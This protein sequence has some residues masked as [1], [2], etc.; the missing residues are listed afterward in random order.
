MTDKNL[1]A[2]MQNQ[3][4]DS[5][6]FETILNSN[7]F[8]L[9]YLGILVLIVHGGSLLFGF[10]RED[11]LLLKHLS[12]WNF[13]EKVFGYWRPV[14]L[15]WLS[16]QYTL[17]GLNP[18]AMH[19]VSLILFAVNCWLA[20]Y[21]IISLGI[22]R[23]VALVSV[24]LWIIMSG[25]IDA[26]VWISECNDLLAMFFLLLASLIWLF[27]C[28]GNKPSVFY[29]LLAGIC[30]LFSILNKEVGML[31]PIGA[32]IIAFLKSG[33]SGNRFKRPCYYY[34]V[35]SLPFVFMVIYVLM[36]IT[37]QG[38]SAGLNLYEY[39]GKEDAAYNYPLILKLVKMTIHY[40]EGIFYS[41]LPL[42]LFLSWTGLI[43]GAFASISLIFCLV[44]QN[45]KSFNSNKYLLL[46]G[47]LWILFFSLHTSFNTSVRTQYIATFGTSFVI[48]LLIFLPQTKTL[49]KTT[50]ICFAIYIGMH[51]LLG[52]QV[53]AYFS[54]SSTDTIACNARIL[55]SF[56]ISEE[57]KEYLKKDLWYVDFDA[58]SDYQDIM[59]VDKGPWKKAKSWYFQR[60]ITEKFVDEKEEQP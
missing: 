26:A 3:S 5:L 52:K 20:F 60:L 29:V 18:F 15:L 35:M 9:F 53:A 4:A 12:E 37:A 7:I 24:S 46:G 14:W 13:W 30:W 21:L 38:S 55:K 42:E 6:R 33:D 11:I 56:P 16:F 17:F 1:F 45:I 40:M 59:F 36:K 22:K 54:P 48:S 44:W 2:K 47:V 39:A 51:L 49:F 32:V 34:F 50:F 41:F 58:L 25:N 31:W 19:A 8:A 10:A 23:H 27:F 57:K 28:I 43:I